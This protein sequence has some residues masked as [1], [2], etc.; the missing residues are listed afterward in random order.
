MSETQ[1]APET[2]APDAPADDLRS[3]LSAA[4]EAPADTAQ[5]APA[6]GAEQRARDA[7]GRFASKADEPGPQAQA[8]AEAQTT[9][10]PG[11]KAAE[12]A[13]A[14]AILPPQSWSASAKA[15]FA[16]LPPEVQ[17]EVLRRE[18]DVER[19]F[20]EKGEALKSWEPISQAIEPI[21]AKL[22]M[23]GVSPTQFLS[24]LVAAHNALETQPQ[25]ALAYLARQY[26]VDL[27]QLAQPAPTQQQAADPHFAQLQQELHEVKGTL[28]QQ[29]QAAQQAQ[30]T[31]VQR[32]IEA[33]AADPKHVHFETVRSTMGALIQSGQA[34]DL[35]EA[36]DKAV[37]SHPQTRAAMLEQQRQSDLAE[38]QKQANAARGR[39]VSVT[40][41]PSAGS[42]RIVPDSLRGELEAAFAGNIH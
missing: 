38:R 5:D 18:S 30:A 19:G 33:F 32:G 22:A 26:G 41:S 28:A 35:A 29:Q 10:Q 16:E 34:K 13:A 7:Q 14:P 11:N 8:P 31:E 27:R 25:Q 23:A 42:N 12:P 4:F 3:V 1:A 2:A 9:D 40:G 15:R 21:K 37:W 20:R 39:A 36:Y 17:Q 24:N 6:E